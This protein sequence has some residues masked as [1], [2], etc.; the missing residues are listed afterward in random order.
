MSQRTLRDVIIESCS[1]NL[2][3][4]HL[5][6]LIQAVEEFVQNNDQPC[7][8][9]SSKCPNCESLQKNAL[10]ANLHSE[11]WKR[12]AEE[13]ALAFQSNFELLKKAENIIGSEETSVRELTK[14]PLFCDNCDKLM[15]QNGLLRFENDNHLMDI[16]TLKLKSTQSDIDLARKDI[17][18][19]HLESDNEWLKKELEQEQKDSSDQIEDLQKKIDALPKMPPNHNRIPSK[20]SF[21]CASAHPT[22]RPEPT[23]PN[24]R[25]PSTIPPV[26]EAKYNKTTPPTQKKPTILKTRGTGRIGPSLRK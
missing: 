10:S 21:T 2:K 7:P 3:H 25:I 22:A 1:H 24:P 16:R 12:L 15:Q 14:S 9:C 23:T 6:K 26:I 20:E 18:I 8:V 4:I 19:K 17:M 13:N 5:Q 11:E